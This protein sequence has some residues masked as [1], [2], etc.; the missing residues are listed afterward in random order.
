MVD[1]TLAAALPDRR[2]AL[3]F[4]GKHLERMKSG[5]SVY[6]RMGHDSLDTLALVFKRAFDPALTA[7]PPVAQLTQEQLA[8]AIKALR[9]TAPRKARREIEDLAATITPERLQSWVAGQ[10]HSENR[11][12]L[13]IS[14]DLTQSVKVILSLDADLA[15]FELEKVPDRIAHLRKSEEVAELLRYLS[16]DDYFALRK[17]LGLALDTRR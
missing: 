7:G 1:D 14:N 8:A 2:A 16:S 3:F 4:L 13:L 6:L 9:K 10:R 12:G 5:Y 17:I 15:K 11:A